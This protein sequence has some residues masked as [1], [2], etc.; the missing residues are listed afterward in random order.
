MKNSTAAVA[1]SL[2][3]FASLV[4]ADIGYQSPISYDILTYVIVLTVAGVGGW[5][6]GIH[7]FLED[8]KRPHQALRF[9]HSIIGAMFVGVLT[10]WYCQDAGIG[11]LKTNVLVGLNSFVGIGALKIIKML[12]D[13]SRD[14]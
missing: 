13:R 1:V 12:L 10:F 6:T 3:V 11:L 5:L 4:F 8:D 7:K 14:K 9:V 2:V